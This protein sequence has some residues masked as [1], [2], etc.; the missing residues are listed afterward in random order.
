MKNYYP[1]IQEQLRVETNNKHAGMVETILREI[2]NKNIV[3]E[4]CA[5]FIQLQNK[6]MH[7]YDCLITFYR[8]YQ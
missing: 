2:E 5:E 3:T 4:F 6:G 8:N 1:Y 7:P